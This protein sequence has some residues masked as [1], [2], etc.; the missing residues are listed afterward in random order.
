MHKL[1]EEESLYKL[2]K[3]LLLVGKENLLNENGAE[4]KDLENSDLRKVLLMVKQV[5]KMIESRLEDEEK[6]TD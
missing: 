6:S 5:E 2:L 3:R 4:R 1:I